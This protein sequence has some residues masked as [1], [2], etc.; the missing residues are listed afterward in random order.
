MV[1]GFNPVRYSVIKDKNPREIVMLVGTGCKW[2]RCTFCDYHLDSSPDI[3]ANFEINRKALENITGQY[4]KL[5]VINSGSFVDLDDDTMKLVLKICLDKNIRE[6]H[7]ECHWMH[8]ENVKDFKETFE[9]YGIKVLVKLGLETFDLE[10]REKVLVKGIEERTPEVIAGYF[11][12]INLLQGI[13]GQ[14]ADSMIYD[15]EIGLKHFERV[16]V[17]IMT[18]NTTKIKPDQNVINEFM[19]YVYPKFCDNNRVDILITNTDFG[20]GGNQNE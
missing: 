13:T 3:T 7:F 16:C 9:K 17:N 4:G 19:K 14:T 12:E 10:M 5:E 6:V 15:I 8:K 2:R 11:D 18:P 1:E 20:V